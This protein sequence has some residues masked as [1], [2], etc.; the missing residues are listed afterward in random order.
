M[1]RVWKIEVYWKRTWSNG[2]RI[3]T[4]KEGKN[5]AMHLRKSSISM[6]AFVVRI[7]ILYIYIF[8]IVAKNVDFNMKIQIIHQHDLLEI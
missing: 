5:L 4:E 6:D 2:F 7:R 3:Y 8:T 1:A